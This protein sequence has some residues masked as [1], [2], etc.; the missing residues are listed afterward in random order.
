MRIFAAILGAALILLQYRLWISDRG[1]SEV[2]RLQASVDAQQAANREQS[3][4]NRQLAAEVNNLK[5]GVNALEERARSELGMVGASETFYQVV[6]PTTPAPAAPAG[7]VTARTVAAR[8][9]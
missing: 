6:A 8:A 4:R 9:Q 1:F 3:E 7:A 2:A 5:G